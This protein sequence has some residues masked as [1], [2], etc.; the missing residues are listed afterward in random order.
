MKICFSLAMISCVLML[1]FSVA[2][3]VDSDEVESLDSP[4]DIYNS[5]DGNH[6]GFYPSIDILSAKVWNNESFIVFELKVNGS[7]EDNASVVYNFDITSL[8]N[9]TQ[10][11][12]VAYNNYSAYVYLSGQDVISC[13][14]ETS[15]GTL[16]I[17]V[18]KNDLSSIES[19]WSLIASAS[20][21]TYR[22]TAAIA[23]FNPSI[24]EES[25]SDNSTPGFIFVG[26]VAAL[27][28]CVYLRKR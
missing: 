13:L 28:I 19:P 9:V 14:N 1:S 26:V 16:T 10:K 3:V 23:S 18:D 27:I 2:A 5:L 12:R 25:G 24:D 8:S 22:D 21:D 20:K 11:A 6:S 17:F 15:S 7:I 4:N